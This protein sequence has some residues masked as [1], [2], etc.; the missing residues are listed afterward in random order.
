MSSRPPTNSNF[1]IIVKNEVGFLKQLNIELTQ[2]P[3]IPL[4]GIFSRGMKT[5]IH[6]KKLFI[7]AK[8]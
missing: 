4:P 8:S 6:I 1:L 7:I 2:D 3:A 5:H